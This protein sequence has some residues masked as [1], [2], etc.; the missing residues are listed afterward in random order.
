MA[1]HTRTHTHTHTHTHTDI[2]HSTCQD[3][4]TIQISEDTRKLESQFPQSLTNSKFW[5]Y[6]KYNVGYQV[7]F[8]DLIFN[9]EFLVN[10]QR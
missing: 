3:Q 4:K 10:A 6:L 2:L 8:E 7:R 1:S 5:I 9:K